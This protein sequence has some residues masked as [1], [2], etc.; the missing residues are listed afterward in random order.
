MS[1]MSELA[2]DAATAA[3]IGHNNPPEPTPYETVSSKADDLMT[4][5]RNW[6]DGAQ[7]ESQA[8][9]DEIAKL[10]DGFRKLT[11]EADEAR[12]E[13][14]RPFDEGKAAV[15]AKYAP[16]IAD[17]KAQRGKLVIAV[18]TLK[19]TLAPWL[20]KLDEEKRA[21]AEKARQEAE[22]K[23]KAAAEAA[24]AAQ[25]NDLAAQEEAAE[26]IAAAETAQL[27]AKRA[28]KARAHANGGGRAMGLRTYYTPTLVNSRVA[29][30]HY[31]KVQPDTVKAFLIKLAETDIHE[32][33]RAIP[34][35]DVAEEKRVA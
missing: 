12:K 27:D 4:E 21:T 25:A 11:A 20:V 34:G 22:A 28:E 7:V 14:N 5:A 16:L 24:R 2:A 8:Q 9:A 29:L 23:A 17:T 15:Q 33:K 30:E 6:C 32:G 13:E 1:A 26:L 10:I 3:H 35:F 19:K 18:E 31:V